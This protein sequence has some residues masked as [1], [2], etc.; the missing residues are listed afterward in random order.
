M[1]S[2]QLDFQIKYSKEKDK[3]VQSFK[4][5]TD[6][7]QNEFKLN[8]DKYLNAFQE[9]MFEIREQVKDRKIKFN[10]DENSVGKPN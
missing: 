6:N 3:E 8:R 4:G 9:N 7:Y 1:R 5:Y 2:S 10:R